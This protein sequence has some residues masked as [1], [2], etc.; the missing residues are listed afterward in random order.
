MS[1][2]TGAAIMHYYTN[3][4]LIIIDSVI[5]GNMANGG[6]YNGLGGTGKA[7]TTINN[8]N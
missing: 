4:E 6:A 7:T 8:D 1:I 2:F 5:E 3:S